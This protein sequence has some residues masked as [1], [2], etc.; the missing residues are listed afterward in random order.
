MDKKKRRSLV[1]PIFLF[2]LSRDIFSPHLA[3]ESKVGR[4]SIE[5][6]GVMRRS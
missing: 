2:P 4:A 1:F 6:I 5:M 3:D